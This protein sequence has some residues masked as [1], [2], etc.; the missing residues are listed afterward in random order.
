MAA[1]PSTISGIKI[2][3]QP[4]MM[5]AMA[6]AEPVWLPPEFLISRRAS[7]DFDE[8]FWRSANPDGI[9]GR[10]GNYHRT[11]STYLNTL[12]GFGFH[13]DAF[14]EPL[15]SPLLSEWEPVYSNLPIFFA[16]RS[17]LLRRAPGAP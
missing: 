10:V 12:A 2:P 16:A 3:A 14:E 6:K 5:P 9:R 15:P 17:L 8:G 4:R 11:L 7:S 1:P 13:L